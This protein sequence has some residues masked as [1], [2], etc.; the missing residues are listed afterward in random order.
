MLE[1][2][3]QK[4]EEDFGE[5]LKSLSLDNS[6]SSESRDT[7]RIVRRVYETAYNRG[8]AEGVGL[9]IKILKIK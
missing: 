6:L 9:T 7:L 1:E 8:F 3:R 2:M 5:L 4:L